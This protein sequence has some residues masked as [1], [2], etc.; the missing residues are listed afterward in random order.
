MNK[1]VRYCERCGFRA[2]VYFT[3]EEFHAA[4]DL[5]QLVLRAVRMFD[6]GHVC[7]KERA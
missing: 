5:A 2:E 3:D 4:L 7:W 1:I 6:A